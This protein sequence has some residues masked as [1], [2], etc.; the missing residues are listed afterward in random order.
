M[1]KSDLVAICLAENGREQDKNQRADVRQMFLIQ[2][3][4]KYDLKMIANAKWMDMGA[5]KGSIIMIND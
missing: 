4:L 3:W 1:L 2:R 5:F